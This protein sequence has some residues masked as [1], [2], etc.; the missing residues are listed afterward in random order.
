MNDKPKTQALEIKLRKGISLETACQQ[1]GMD[2]EDAKG[3]LTAKNEL[4]DFNN[5]AD[6]LWGRCATEDAVNELKRIITAC[7]D[8]E[9][10]RRAAKDLLEHFRSERERLE[11]EV[12]KKQTN[13]DRMYQQDIFDNADC[14]WD[15]STKSDS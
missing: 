5:L 1:L 8:D 10:K 11:R 9:T 7:E 13:A 15:F 6:G 14:P 12:K 3:W 2:I 4:N